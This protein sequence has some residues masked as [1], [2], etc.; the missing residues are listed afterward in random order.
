MKSISFRQ[1]SEV[2]MVASFL[3]GVVFPHKSHSSKAAF[4]N[5]QRLP[6]FKAGINPFFAKR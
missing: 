5:L 3:P 2:Y 1:E 6:T 4:L